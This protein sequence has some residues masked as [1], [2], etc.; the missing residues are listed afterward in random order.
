MNVHQ[1]FRA[2]GALAVVLYLAAIIYVGVL[3]IRSSAPP[4]IPPIVDYYVT[5][6]SAT[7]ATFLGMVLG[8]QQANV[9]SGLPSTP[10]RPVT[11]LTWG[12]TIAAWSYV[13]S[14]CLA[15]LFWILDGP[16]SATAAPLIQNLTKSLIG[17]FV[18]VLTVYLNVQGSGTPGT[19]GGQTSPQEPPGASPQH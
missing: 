10:A 15:L 19:G 5:S 1:L 17:L 16:F 9:K 6:I 7:L 3:G 13:A 4:N 8:F 12:Q 2:L 14:L 18:G 11:Q